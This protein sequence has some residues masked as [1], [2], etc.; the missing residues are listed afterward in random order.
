MG[1]SVGPWQAYRGNDPNIVSDGAVH[2][3]D[4][5]ALAVKPQEVVPGQADAADGRLF[6]EASMGPMPIVAMQP[7]RERIAALV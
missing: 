4:S 3:P 5:A 7:W 2:L 6:G 1:H